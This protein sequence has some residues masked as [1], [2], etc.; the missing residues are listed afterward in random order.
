MKLQILK[1]TTSKRVGVFIQST[2]VSTGAG[3][4]GLV[5]NSAGLTWYYWRE[6]EGNAGATAVTLATATRGTFTSGGFI[7]KD[8]TN[9]P[10]FYELGIP[11]AALATGANWVNMI[12]KGATNM[13]PLPLEIE[14]TDFSLQ[15][16]SALDL[17]DFADDGYDPSTNKVTGVVLTDTVTTYTGNTVQTGDSF[18]RL[19][20]PAGAS[21]SAD[22]AAIKT[23]VDAILVDTGTTLDS[24]IDAIKAQ[25][26]E[27]VFTVAGQVDATAVTVADKTGYAL[28]GAGNVAVAAAIA[29]RALAAKYGSLTWEEALAV[30]LATQVGITSGAGTGTFTIRDLID[31]SDVVVASTS[32]GNR[33]A[34]TVTP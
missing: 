15:G 9:M 23:V 11:N 8:A 3:L 26:D 17:K 4:T 34:T 14:L 1:G 32:G 20:A 7:E 12:L 18:A 28:S 31:A 6:D 16:Q 25:T 24:K 21:V 2:A 13:A 33:T 19:G 30:V 27:F 29:A 5:F 22:I 10:G